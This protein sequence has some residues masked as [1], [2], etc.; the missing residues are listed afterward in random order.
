MADLPLLYKEV[1]TWRFRSSG[2]IYTICHTG[3]S[4]YCFHHSFNHL[5]CKSIEMKTYYFKIIFFILYVISIGQ[6]LFNVSG[7]YTP[8]AKKDPYYKN[9]DE[10]FY[11]A[12]G[13]YSWFT[14]YYIK[15]GNRKWNSSEGAY[16]WQRTNR[17]ELKITF[18][19][20]ITNSYTKL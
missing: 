9:L 1:T 16:V 20:P 18:G 17:R 12:L 13:N 7:W 6:L 15:H 3:D 2:W 8:S 11:L 19:N 5:N 10:E 14:L 4:N